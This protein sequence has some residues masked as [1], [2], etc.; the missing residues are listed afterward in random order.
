ML[1]DR[2]VRLSSPSIEQKAKAYIKV[3]LAYEAFR[4]TP[5]VN[6]FVLSSVMRKVCKTIKS[7][8]TNLDKNGSDLAEERT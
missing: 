8:V 3:D 6:S 4:S 5:G 2:I 7:S 1:S